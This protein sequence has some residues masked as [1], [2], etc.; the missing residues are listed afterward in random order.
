VSQQDCL[1]ATATCGV[2]SAQL[3]FSP[4]K[5]SGHS[6][7]SQAILN[8]DMYDYCPLCAQRWREIFVPKN[9]LDCAELPRNTPL[10][11]EMRPLAPNCMNCAECAN[12]AKCAP[13]RRIARIAPN[14]RIA[15]YCAELRRNAPIHYCQPE[16]AASI[17]KSFDKLSNGLCSVFI[18]AA[19]AF[20]ILLTRTRGCGFGAFQRNTAQF[21]HLAQFAQFGANRAIRRKGAHLA[22]FAHSRNRRKGAHFSAKG[23]ISTQR[24]LF[25]GIF[26]NL[27]SE[28]KE[29]KDSNAKR[30]MKKYQTCYY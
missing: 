27:C 8:N 5:F 9:M 28:K 29:D 23:P 21:A 1:R 25:R 2:F 15:P 12:C 3:D 18:A 6:I 13:L 16:D 19:F 7:T 30:V 11:A 22:Q 20:L 14:A 17:G 4:G 10:C 24:G 26:V